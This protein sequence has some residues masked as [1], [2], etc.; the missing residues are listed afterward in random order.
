MDIAAIGWLNDAGTVAVIKQAAASGS[1]T[2][3]SLSAGQWSSLYSV[4]VK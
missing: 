3:L 1:L 4:L 2:S